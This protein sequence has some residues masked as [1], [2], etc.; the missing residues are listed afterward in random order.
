MLPPRR[1][2]MCELTTDEL[3]ARAAALRAMAETA[4]T[5]DIQDALYRLATPYERLADDRVSN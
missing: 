5:K 1:K 3:R 2:P 4:T